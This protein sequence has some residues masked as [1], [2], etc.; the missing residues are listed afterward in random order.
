MI[1]DMT[2]WIVNPD[3]RDA[4]ETELSTCYTSG[5][6]V[7]ACSSNLVSSLSLS[8]RVVLRLCALLMGLQQREKGECALVITGAA[9]KVR[10]LL[11]TH[12][13]THTHTHTGDRERLIVSMVFTTIARAGVLSGSAA[14][15]LQ[16]LPLGHLLPRDPAA[17]G[18]AAP[19]AIILLP[20]RDSFQQL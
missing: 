18:M 12:T 9:L 11:L 13:H 17:E 14:G 2:I 19:L 15:G 6:R 5:K 10:P 1:G 3:D 4:V 8:L 20:F 7:R 16:A